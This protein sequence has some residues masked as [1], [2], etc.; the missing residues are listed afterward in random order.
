MLEYNTKSSGKT[1]LDIVFFNSVIDKVIK[2]NRAL[3]NYGSNTILVALEGSGSYELVKISVLLS[4]WTDYSLYDKDSEHEED[5][6]LQLKEVL[7]RVMN[8]PD[9]H[10]VLHV[11]E[12]DLSCQGML[13]SLNAIAAHNEI[14]QY[15]SKEEQESLVSNLRQQK[16]ALLVNEQ[17]NAQI[18][19]CY[20]QRVKEKLKTLI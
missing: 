10:F 3:H 19:D 17:T 5:W 1:Q 11:E 18:L 4:D 2:I 16:G 13:E 9:Q 12:R 7:S 15:F 8:E 14:F 20:R 6:R